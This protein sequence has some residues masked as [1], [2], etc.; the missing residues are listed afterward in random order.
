MYNIFDQPF[1]S[2]HCAAYSG[3]A[4]RFRRISQTQ[5]VIA[6]FQRLAAADETQAAQRTQLNKTANYFNTF[7]K[8]A[9]ENGLL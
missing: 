4:V 1:L 9:N 3:L 5:Q 8:K 6:E 7:A 2:P